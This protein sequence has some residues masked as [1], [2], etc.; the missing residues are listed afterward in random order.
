MEF[1][2]DNPEEDVYLKQLLLYVERSDRKMIAEEKIWAVNIKKIRKVFILYQSFYFLN[3]WNA[4]ISSPQ[5][6]VERESKIEFEWLSEYL[7][8]NICSKWY[9]YSFNYFSRE[10]QVTQIGCTTRNDLTLVLLLSSMP[11][12]QY[13][14]WEKQWT[15]STKK[16]R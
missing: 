4:L 12:L 13:T 3:V 6:I 16:W 11:E 7:I 8:E 1:K 9:N 14:W 15:V 10:W 2:K 5:N